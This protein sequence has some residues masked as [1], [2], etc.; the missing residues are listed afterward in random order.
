[1][2]ML[3]TI[4]KARSD[5]TLLCGMVRHVSFDNMANRYLLQAKSVLPWQFRKHQSPGPSAAARSAS[6]VT[7]KAEQ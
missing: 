7:A 4:K 3:L 5:S 1:M 2:S 6:V